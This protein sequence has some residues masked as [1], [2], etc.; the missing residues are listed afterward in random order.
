MK[1][2]V[3][4]AI[5]IVLAYLMFERIY[6]SPEENHKYQTDLQGTIET[7]RWF[8]WLLFIGNKRWLLEQFDFTDDARSKLQKEDIKPVSRA[9]VLEKFKAGGGKH[10]EP[11]RSLLFREPKDI[12]LLLLERRELYTAMTFGVNIGVIDVPKIPGKGAM[13]YSVIFRYYEPV[14]KSL[15]KKAARKTANAV[16]FLSRFGTTGKWLVVNYSYTYS[17]SDYA[18]WYLREGDS[19]VSQTQKETMTY[20]ENLKTREGLQ[21]M[22][23]SLEENAAVFDLWAKTWVE[24]HPDHI[25]AQFPQ[26]PIR[27]RDEFVSGWSQ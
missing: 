21:N 8:S 26:K 23:R 17:Q 13:L 27:E 19:S 16:P 20:L 24:K 10:G 5:L 3:V 15:W 14:N 11:L 2:K 12:E 6:D 18:I 22:M 9:G 1:N 4:I 7:G 25:D